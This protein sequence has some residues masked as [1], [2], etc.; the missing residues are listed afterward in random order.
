MIE[1]VLLAF[2]EAIKQ[3]ENLIY[4]D[5]KADSGDQ[6]KGVLATSEQ[7]QPV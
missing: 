6:P 1:I 5:S 3:F 7:R 2:S 4:E